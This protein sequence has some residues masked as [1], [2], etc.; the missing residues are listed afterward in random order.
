MLS[1]KGALTA[2]ILAA[3]AGLSADPAAAQ[4]LE[5]VRTLAAEA[6]LRRIL[7]ASLPQAVPVRAVLGA[8]L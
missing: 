7:A 8:A 4:T 6:P 2:C 3:A 1:R 5:S